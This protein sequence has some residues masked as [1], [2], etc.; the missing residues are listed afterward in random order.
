ML[1]EQ[2][3][4]KINLDLHVLGKR[5][6]GYHDLLSEVAFAELADVLEFSRA[7]TITLHVDGE[8]AD[9]SGSLGDNLVL[10]AANALNAYA[11]THHGASIRLTK[12]IPVGAGLGGGSADAAATLRGLNRLWKLNLPMAALE[13]IALPLGADVPMCLHSVN[14]T[15]EGVGERL[16]VHQGR[17]G[18]VSVWLVIVFPRVQLATVEV[19][20]RYERD[21]LAPVPVGHVRPLFNDLEYTARKLCPAIGEVLAALGTVASSDEERHQPRMSG[22]GTSCFMML[23]DESE[24]RNVARTL[25]QQHH[26]WWIQAT[27]MGSI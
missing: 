27:R 24:A 18:P 8:F 9:A 20:R 15:A 25:Q 14:L 12:N 1:R 23:R 4:A 11:G 6:D 10:K 5:A 2:A 17:A 22:S 16:T 26:Y 3:K 21:P 19:F 13:A 7:D